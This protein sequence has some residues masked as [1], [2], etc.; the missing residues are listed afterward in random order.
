[1]TWTRLLRAAPLPGRQS[2][3]APVAIKLKQ[4]SVFMPDPHMDLTRSV[5]L[6]PGRAFSA[7]PQG[8]L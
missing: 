6:N 8:M 4:V 5:L 1:M 7:L 2:P 3:L